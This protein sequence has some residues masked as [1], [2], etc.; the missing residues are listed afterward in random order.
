M[1]D[2]SYEIASADVV[3][4][5]TAWQAQ[6]LHDLLTTLAD[7]QRGLFDVSDLNVTDEVAELCA[8]IRA[9]TKGA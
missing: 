7:V 4:P 6:R 5:L 8:V 1:S 3:L 2:E 9:N